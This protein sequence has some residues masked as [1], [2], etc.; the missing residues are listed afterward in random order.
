MMT[1]SQ[2]GFFFFFLQINKNALINLRGQTA[3][4]VVMAQS[5]AVPAVA[6][7]G[8]I[9]PPADAPTSGIFGLSH[10]SRP[11]PG[12]PPPPRELLDKIISGVRPASLAA[13]IQDLSPTPWPPQGGNPE[14]PDAPVCCTPGAVIPSGHPHGRRPYGIALASRA[15]DS[16]PRH[17][18]VVFQDSPKIILQVLQA[19]RPCSLH[20]SPQ[21]KN[22]LC[23]TPKTTPSNPFFFSSEP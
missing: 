16:R 22:D 19:S 2:G 11:L 13:G 6:A 3:L 15:P 21:K 5:A 14:R 9:D 1:F 4:R 23:L 12:P 8:P 7:S 20:S 17:P 18:V 10:Q